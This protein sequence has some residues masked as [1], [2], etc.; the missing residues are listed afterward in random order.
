LTTAITLA[1]C[2]IVLCVTGVLAVTQLGH[3]DQQAAACPSGSART[4]DVVAIVACPGRWVPSTLKGEVYALLQTAPPFASLFAGTTSGLR[5]SMDGGRSW[6]PDRGVLGKTSILALP[7]HPIEA[8][9]LPAR[10]AAR[11]IS[12]CPAS[13]RPGA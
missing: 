1:I 2:A 9:S 4:L 3:T 13:P 6:S 10:T 12:V 11:S 8:R 7:R 5:V